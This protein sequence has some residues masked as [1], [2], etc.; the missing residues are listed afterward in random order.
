MLT[1]LVAR[2]L[3]PYRLQ[4]IVIVVAQ[5]CAQIAALTLPTIN[6]DIINQGVVR[7]DTGYVTSHS[8]LMLAVALG[9]TI[10][11]VIAVFLAAQVAMRM[12]RDIRDAVF[13]RTL[14]F[15]AREVNQFGAPSLI[16]RTTNDVQQVQM[17]V[18]MTLAVLIGAPIMMVVGVVMAIRAEVSLSWIIAVA[19]TS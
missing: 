1:Q 11:Q 16:T 18:F 19:V 8:L 2:H 4:V 6:A 15:S 7:V 14:D 5:I 3:R 10:C 12:G 13:T 9:Q 17:L